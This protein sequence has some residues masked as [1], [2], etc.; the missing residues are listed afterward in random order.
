LLIHPRDRMAVLAMLVAAGNPAGV[1]A[2]AANLQPREAETLAGSVSTLAPHWHHHLSR[3]ALRR[4]ADRTDGTT[5][6]GCR[7]VV[8]GAMSRD[9]RPL[10]L[11]RPLRVTAAAQLTLLVTSGWETWPPGTVARHRCTDPRCVEPRCLV[12][13]SI[14][15]NN[16]DRRRQRSAV[17][18]EARPTE[19]VINTD[20]FDLPYERLKVLADIERALSRLRPA[21]GGPGGC[22]VPRGT[23]VD[24]V[25]PGGAYRRV[26]VGGTDVALH[27][28][29]L[30]AVGQLPEDLKGLH[31]CDRPACA[32][33]AHLSPGTLSR[34]TREA[35]AR[36][37]LGQGPSHVRARLTGPQVV[38]ARRRV[39]A[40]VSD[41]AS[42]AARCGVP[43]ILM[44][45]ALVGE[46]YANVAEPAVG[47]RRRRLSDRGVQVIRT[48]WR[49]GIE[50]ARLARA[51]G[52][53]RRYLHDLATG[54]VRPDSGGQPA[55]P[56][57]HAR[58]TA[59]NTTSL[60]EHAVATI[61]RQVSSGLS[62][63]AVARLHG[64]HPS[65]VERIVS[66]TTWRHLQPAS[67]NGAGL[68]PAV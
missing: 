33:V 40:G 25:G 22:L 36:G 23:T 55:E 31:S 8:R 61:R 9:G 51:T 56:T 50:P 19:S 29:V 3:L 6:W 24:I 39:R 14:A 48:L 62:C 15:D 42:E 63:A 49:I 41:A 11:S 52:L 67:P 5:P 12:P 53:G 66:G 17:P 37:W 13:G 4:L 16:E 28:L 10:T 21:V 30:E 38:D 47:Q 32:A 2:A 58:R 68:V 26:R 54:R 46:T 65:T 60:N 43:E 7:L 34:N 57:R 35:I 1:V 45:R 59:S 20:A 64:V 44:Q 18:I 27:R